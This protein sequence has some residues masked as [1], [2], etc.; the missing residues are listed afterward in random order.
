MDL[1]APDLWNKYSYCTGVRFDKIA[2]YRLKWMQLCT[3]LWTDHQLCHTNSNNAISA[4]RD[5]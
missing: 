4:H 1:G 3:N 5:T 2:S